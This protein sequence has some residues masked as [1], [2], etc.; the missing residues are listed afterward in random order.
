VQFWEDTKEPEESEAVEIEI[1]FEGDA[2]FI[3]GLGEGEYCSLPLH[4]VAQAI[5]DGTRPVRGSLAS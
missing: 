3:D 2:F 1:G 5:A 4:A